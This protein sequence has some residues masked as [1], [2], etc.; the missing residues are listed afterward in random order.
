MTE[1]D[2]LLSKADA[3]LARR[4]SSVVVPQPPADY[5]VLTEVVDAS[6]AAAAQVAPVGALERA[7]ELPHLST[8]DVTS[9]A[10]EADLQV[11][12]ERVRLRVLDTIEPRLHEFLE[13]FLRLHIGDLA[14]QLATN[15]RS[16]TRNEIIALVR[17]TVRDAVNRELRTKHDDRA[18]GR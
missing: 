8:L 9:L 2:E 18:K 6:A 12:E 1:P 7:Q 14:R 11:L 4:R 13:E 16:E 3:L 17:E 5:P 10:S 15:M